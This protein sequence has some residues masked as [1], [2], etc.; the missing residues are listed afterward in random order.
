VSTPEQAK[1]MASFSDGVIIGSAVVRTL[2]ENRALSA[3]SYAA[4]FI[5]PFARALGKNQRSS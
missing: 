3:Q 5:R 4:K 1:E 2:H